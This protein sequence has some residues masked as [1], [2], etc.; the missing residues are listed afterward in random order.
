MTLAYGHQN[1][2]TPAECSVDHVREAS[3]ENCHCYDVVQIQAFYKHPQE[4]G[5]PCVLQENVCRFAKIELQSID[6]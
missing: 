4:H 6:K 5:R 1:G 2:C 3:L